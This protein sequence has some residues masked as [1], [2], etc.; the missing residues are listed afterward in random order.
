MFIAEPPERI[1]LFVFQRRGAA[2]DW[3][4]EMK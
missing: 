4:R 1:I 2:L 3:M